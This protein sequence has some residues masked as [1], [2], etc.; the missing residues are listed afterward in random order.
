MN[1]RDRNISSLLWTLNV[2]SYT[3]CQHCI[4]HTMPYITTNSLKSKWQ[5]LSITSICW[6]VKSRNVSWLRTEITDLGPLQPMLVPRP[7]FNLSTTSLFS[8]SP[9]VSFDSCFGRSWYDFICFVTKEFTSKAPNL[10]TVTVNNH[11][12]IT[13]DI[14]TYKR[15][16]WIW[17]T[18]Q[19]SLYSYDYSNKKHL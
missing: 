16:S 6:T 19:T 18:V 5:N 3:I 7:P 17:S 1:R 4:V 9:M 2:M 13:I 15:A 14:C 11:Q 10:I 12:L 8:M